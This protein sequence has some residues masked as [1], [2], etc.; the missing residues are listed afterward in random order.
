VVGRTHAQTEHRAREV[1]RES[2]HVLARGGGVAW[3]K[4]RVDD[5]RGTEREKGAN[6]MAVDVDGFVVQ[7]GER[8]EGF[9]EGERWRPVA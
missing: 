3:G 7:V 9:I 1:T 4:K 5:A 6:E 8:S 2:V